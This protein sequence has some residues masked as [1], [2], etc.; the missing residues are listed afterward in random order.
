MNIKERTKV[1]EAMNTLALS[2]NAEDY[3]EW[4]LMYGVADGDTDFECYAED[5]DDFADLMNLFLRMM[6]AAKKDGGLYVDGVVSK[7]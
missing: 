2:V 3:L 4:W 1:V 6:C 7:D 5:D